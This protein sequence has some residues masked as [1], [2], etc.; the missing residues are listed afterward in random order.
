[1][2]LYV[3]CLANMNN[4]CHFFDEA[5]QSTTDHQLIDED[6][7]IEWSS[8]GYGEAYLEIFEFPTNVE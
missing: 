6:E 8:C 4:V 1:M 3:Y 2:I 7:L 5:K